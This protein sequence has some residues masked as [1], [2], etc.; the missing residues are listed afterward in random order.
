M[1]QHPNPLKQIIDEIKTRL[2]ELE[3]E[4]KN[5]KWI[6]TESLKIVEENELLIKAMAL[7]IEELTNVRFKH[8]LD[9]VVGLKP[10]RKIMRKPRE[11]I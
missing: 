10:E 7:D 1:I 11:K 5:I 8:S 9:P 3:T 6:S 2:D 4:M